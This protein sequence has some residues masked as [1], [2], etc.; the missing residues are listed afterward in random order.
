MSLEKP[1]QVRFIELMPF[2]GGIHKFQRDHI[3]SENELCNKITAALGPLELQHE[4]RLDGEARVYALPKAKG[5]LGFISSV[6]APFCAGCNRARLTADGNLRLCL[7][8]DNEVDLKG[9]LRAGMD[10]ASLEKCLRE[11]I[12]KKPWGHGLDHNEFATNR[13]MSEIGG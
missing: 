9:P 11:G 2:G 7:L 4:G 12:Y 6:T 10:E 3:V 8:R 13:A 5:S 1:W